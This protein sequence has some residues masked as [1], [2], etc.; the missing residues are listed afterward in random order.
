[1]SW[2]CHPIFLDIGGAAEHEL[3]TLRQERTIPSDRR[4]LSND[5]DSADVRLG[6]RSTCG[7]LSSHSAIA[8]R[9]KLPV[10][11]MLQRGPISVT[12]SN[13]SH[14]VTSVEGKK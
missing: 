2:S 4:R 9:R 10:P 1:M 8:L 7:V 12:G 11:G 5:H 6:E 13:R 14:G 3:G